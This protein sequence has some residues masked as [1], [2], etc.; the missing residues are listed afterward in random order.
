[1]A[2]A[3]ARNWPAADAIASHCARVSTWYWF[4][5]EA[6]TGES[7]FGSGAVDPPVEDWSRRA[8]FRSVKP[9]AGEVLRNR[10]MPSAGAHV[11]TRHRR[12]QSAWPN[13]ELLPANCPLMTPA[14]IG[15]ATT[16]NVN[17]A[18]ARRMTRG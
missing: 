9:V 8:G 18:T 7:R 16:A 12:C 15:F 6:R 13:V 2:P 10:L 4:G 11:S 14:A 5:P 17:T 1:M 3:H